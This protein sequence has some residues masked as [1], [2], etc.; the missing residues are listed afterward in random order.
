VP[1]KDR[2]KLVATAKEQ[3][4]EL[5]GDLPPVLR[6]RLSDR[7]LDLDQP[8]R[9]MSQGRERFAGKATR[10]VAAIRASLTERADVSTAATALLQVKP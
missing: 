2:A 9:V 5:E 1:I 10:T 8:L 7:L 3:T 4:I 6:L